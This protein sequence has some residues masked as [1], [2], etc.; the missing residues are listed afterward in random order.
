MSLKKF[1]NNV[2][3]EEVEFEEYDEKYPEYDT[4]YLNDCTEG[5]KFT[6][7]PVLSE[8]YEKTFED[9]YSGKEIT[10]NTIKL[11]VVN[12]ELE[13]VFDASIKL[14]NKENIQDIWKKSKI[15]TLI[16][17]IAEVNEVE[18][19]GNKLSNFNIKEF[20][21]EINE[22][23]EITVEIFSDEFENKKG[24]IIEYNLV[25]VTEIN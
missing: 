23:E 9:K 24:E 13:E 14:K 8:I 12:H 4:Y 17:S 21:D 6:G 10:Q 15:G 16:W 2:E 7:Q 22:M 19:K 3:T 25:K 11:Q 5:D 1:F 18:I 20:S